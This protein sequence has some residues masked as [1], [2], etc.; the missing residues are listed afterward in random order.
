MNE[1]SFQEQTA[2]LALFDC[3]DVKLP[4]LQ[5]VLEGKHAPQKTGE[6][7]IVLGGASSVGKFAIQAGIISPRLLSLVIRLTC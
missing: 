6:W 7:A 1:S 2:G 5:E 4:N 3:L